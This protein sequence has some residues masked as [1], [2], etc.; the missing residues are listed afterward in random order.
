[1]M[2]TIRRNEPSLSH[3]FI[4]YSGKTSLGFAADKIITGEAGME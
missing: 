4:G 2:E 1:M 3:W